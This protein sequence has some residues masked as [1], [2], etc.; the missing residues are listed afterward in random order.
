MHLCY[1]AFYLCAISQVMATGD[2][3]HHIA[4]YDLQRC[5]GRTGNGLCP[6][7]DTKAKP[8]GAGG[9]RRMLGTL[10]EVITLISKSR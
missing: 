7:H 3:V 1:D 9:G 5:Y 6:K 10:T 2:Y 4:Q 8:R